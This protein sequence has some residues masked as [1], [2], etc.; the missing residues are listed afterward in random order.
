MEALLA[1]CGSDS[2]SG[3]EEERI[4][5]G[6]PS[7]K[8]RRSSTAA[9]TTA[10]APPEQHPRV[11]LLPSAAALLDG[12]YSPPP[13][14][15]Q[16]EHEQALLHQG[17]ARAF[18][19]LAGY[20]A[21]HVYLEVETAPN[22]MGPL[23]EL[24][25]A[26]AARLPALQPVVHGSSGGGG[27]G[28][29]GGGTAVAS[30]GWPLEVQ[31]SYHIS[32]SRTVPLL[33]HQI[34]PLADALRRRL[35]RHDTFCIRMGA[36]EVLVNDDRTRTFLVLAAGGG[37][38]GAVEARGGSKAGE[39]G[40]GGVKAALAGGQAGGQ[41]QNV[42]HGGGQQAL[43]PPLPRYSPALVSL[44][45]AVSGVFAAHGLP[46]FY[47]EPRPHVSVAWLL[48]DK[49]QELEAALDAS[50]VAAAAARLQRL[51]AWEAA[52]AAV[53]CKAG[54]RLYF[55]FMRTQVPA[56]LQTDNGLEFCGKEV[57]EL[58]AERV[59]NPLRTSSDRFVWDHW[60]VPG[61]Y[62]LLRT[63]ASAFFPPELYDR[64]EDA[65]VEYGERVLGC[66]GISPVWL[67][68][69]VDGCRQG[70]HS[71]APH[72]PFA[73]V[74]SLTRWDQRRFSGGETALL[75][76]WVLDYWRGFDPRRGTETPQLIT[77]VPPLWNQ[78]TVFDGRLPHSVQQVEGMHDPLEARVVLHGWFTQPSPFFA[79]SL[80][81]EA[82]TPALNACL[83]GLYAALGGLPP[84][85]GVVT[86]RLAVE[87]SGHV[88][89]I[90]WLANTLVARPQGVAAGEAPDEPCQATLATIAEHLLVARFPSNADGG[91]TV[92]TLPFVFE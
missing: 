64:L 71:D 81:E 86:L 87:P 51:P 9:P 37:G 91:E 4:R 49:Q 20:F 11:S 25:Q 60:H 5:G 54:Q 30:A 82:A 18:P 19:H 77:L 73:F 24:L 61:Q 53:V 34:E 38:G 92:V 44:C 6:E 90:A 3:S 2:D 45:H 48:G 84:V 22:W 26:L 62:N 68:Y 29:D 14:A 33:L 88:A 57:K 65:L 21:T 75:Q 52:P 63:P 15:A 72:G 43:P 85:V 83:Q 56:K 17:R 66:R 58:L 31:P 32:L 42:R 80:S 67:S 59:G 70:W 76:P 1:Y 41:Q 89:D 40:S 55:Q 79:G 7:P 69:Y 23:G 35:R 36:P 39:T 78:L 47:A 8:R 50:E 16:R 27:G 10:A 46:R 12:T 28:G 13:A 74:L